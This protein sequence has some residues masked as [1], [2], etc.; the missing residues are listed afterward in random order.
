M[1]ELSGHSRAMTSPLGSRHL[2]RSSM[3]VLLAVALLAGPG[4]V[5][6]WGFGKAQA[7][8]VL[9]F[10]LDFGVGLRLDAAE[11]APECLSA[12]V[13]VGDIPVPRSAVFVALETAA[14]GPVLRVRTT[15]A[16][17]EPLVTVQLSAGC[18]SRATRK[19]TLFADPPGHLA[20]AGLPS[21]EA[22]PSTPPAPQTAPAPA[23]MAAPVTLPSLAAPVPSPSPGLPGEPGP[24]AATTGATPGVDA[25]TRAGKAA[26]APRPRGSDPAETP[27]DVSA[28]ATSANPARAPRS[29]LQLDAPT[30][31]APVAG[32]VLGAGVAAALQSAQDA[33]SAARSAASAAQ[34]RAAEM[35]KSIEALRQEA[36]ANRDALAR[37]TQALQD[38]QSGTPEWL[39]AALVALGGLSVLLFVRMRRL[40][41]GQNLQ[42]QWSW[43]AAVPAAQAQPGSAFSGHVQ[44]PLVP[45][46]PAVALPGVSIDELLDLQQQVEFFSVLGQEEAALNLLLEHLLHT[47]GDYLLPHL[48][49]LEMSRHR[50]DEPAYEA[51]R[52]RFHQRFGAVWPAWSQPPNPQRHLQDLPDVLLDIERVWPDPAQAMVHLEHLLQAADRVDSLDP[53]VQ[54]EVLFLFTVARDL[55]DHPASAP[56]PLDLALPLGDDFAELRAARPAANAPVV[57][58]TSETRV[59]PERFTPPKLDSAA[60]RQDVAPA[61]KASSG[62]AAW[63][64][65]SSLSSLPGIDLLLPGEDEAGSRKAVMPPGGQGRQVKPDELDLMLDDLG[66]ASASSSSPS[67]NQAEEPLSLELPELDLLLSVPGPAIS[68]AAAAV[69][70]D[71]N[72]DELALEW[73][74]PALSAGQEQAA[75]RFSLFGEDLK[76]GKKR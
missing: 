65:K 18:A 32:T 61:A 21:V 4:G 59:T 57:S 49:L 69:D 42:P 54:G 11:A 63:P 35:Q 36:Q 30:L 2:K 40:Q 46:P 7:S 15:V 29:R 16:I 74:Q 60:L 34:A 25:L 68:A 66:V 44:P 72:L 19:F 41:E 38:K 33:A 48:Q 17:D 52:A 22:S 1:L 76:P 67:L 56:A 27:R 5:W 55:R 14:S 39:W 73:P 10:P 6:A 50:A 51:A 75:S 43:G 23:P 53:T 20:A 45:A 26:A 62:D 70:L 47:H 64:P 58:A 31:A 9:G 28:S 8:A 3:Y 12:E 71:L 13:S 24:R 37:L